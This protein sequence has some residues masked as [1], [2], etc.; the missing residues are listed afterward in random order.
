[1]KSNSI[2]ILRNIYSRHSK[3]FLNYTIDILNTIKIDNSV[4]NKHEVNDFIF[5][6]FLKD[7]HLSKYTTDKVFNLVDVDII[8]ESY[9]TY[10]DDKDELENIED[11]D[12]GEH[13]DF[14]IQNKN[15]VNISYNKELATD[16][17]SNIMIYGGL[18]LYK[19]MVDD[20]ID[21]VEKINKNTAEKMRV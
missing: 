7:V 12:I 1:M 10:G 14:S 18:N 13:E 16:I 20:I 8:P 21:D 17:W 11:S 4:I 5:N 19:K 15:K 3:D 2:N 6:T 9:T